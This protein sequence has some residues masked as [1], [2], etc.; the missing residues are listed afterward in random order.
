MQPGLALGW[1]GR[2]GGASEAIAGGCQENATGHITC[3]AQHGW[4]PLTL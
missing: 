2:W 3:K 1:V 4:E